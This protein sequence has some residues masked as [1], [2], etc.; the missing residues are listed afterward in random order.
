MRQVHLLKASCR[1][2]LVIHHSFFRFK[3]LTVR[4]APAFTSDASVAS[5]T[6]MD[7]ESSRQ[8]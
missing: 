1:L 5:S 7:F 3:S 6:E 4:T 2:V 8:D